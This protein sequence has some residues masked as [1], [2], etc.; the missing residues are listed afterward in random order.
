VKN[1]HQNV[2]EAGDMNLPV[3]SLTAGA[4][5]AAT[6]AGHACMDEWQVAPQFL[7]HVW[8]MVLRMCFAN[9]KT[10]EV[11]LSSGPDSVIRTGIAARRAQS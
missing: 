7:R 11:V 9:D 1:R 5:L 2:I 6:L 10:T 4:T 3:G 8:G